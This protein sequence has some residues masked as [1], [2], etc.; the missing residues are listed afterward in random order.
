M[1]LHTD[2]Q[3]DISLV[4]FG[5]NGV[6]T[7]K[8]DV[9]DF[10]LGAPSG[11]LQ[12]VRVNLAA[13][14]QVGPRIAWSTPIEIGLDSACPQITCVELRPGRTVA[15]GTDVEVEVW[16]VDGEM[17][18]TAVVEAGFDVAATGAF[19][20]AAPPVKG[21]KKTPPSWIA[22]VPTKPLQP[23]PATLLVRA[24]DAV[25]NVGPITRVPIDVVSPTELAAQAALGGRVFGT[26]RYGGNPLP[27]AQVVLRDAKQKEIGK[28]VADDKGFFAVEGVAA[29]NYVL[30]VRGLARNRPRT[31][32]QTVVV[33]PPPQKTPRLEIDVK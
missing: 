26:I 13:R 1:R 29:G 20:E 31:A 11:G 30:T 5:Q 16:S 7:V 4:N 33:P 12:N 21:E 27:A 3:A 25:G 18:G 23:G 24:T 14:L 8:T 17:S 10:T 32:E 22:K 15:A 28:A 2:R 9:H 19:S 6:V